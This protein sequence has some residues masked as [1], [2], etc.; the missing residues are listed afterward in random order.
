MTH[1]DKLEALEAKIRD[2]VECPS[3]ILV[4]EIAEW[5]DRIA[6]I[7]AEL[8]QPI[9]YVYSETDATGNKR[10]CAVLQGDYAQSLPN[11][12]AIYAGSSP[13]GEAVPVAYIEE[14]PRVRGLVWA[15]H[16]TNTPGYTFT[17]LYTAP[18]AS[19]PVEATA[20]MEQALRRA[21]GA[22]RSIGASLRD[23]LAAWNARPA[24]HAQPGGGGAGGGI[25]RASG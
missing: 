12:T 4:S 23:A 20:E 15:D 19:V 13:L 10:K 24:I 7:R 21:L 25:A 6:A 11:G 22:G 1:A 8:G 9:G 14:S 17:P 18:P 16:P 5:A 3:V 2:L